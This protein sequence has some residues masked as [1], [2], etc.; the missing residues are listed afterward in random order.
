MSTAV[1]FTCAICLETAV[2]P[3][4][5][6][7]GQ[8]YCRVCIADWLTT[9][10]TCPLTGLHVTDEPTALTLDKSAHAANLDHALTRGDALL[11]EALLNAMQTETAVA[12]AAA[13][14][15]AASA[16][17]AASESTVEIEMTNDSMHH[18]SVFAHH[19]LLTTL[20]VL[21]TCLLHLAWFIL[22]VVATHQSGNMVKT[23]ARRAPPLLVE[24]SGSQVGV[25]LS[26]FADQN[27]LVALGHAVLQGFTLSHL[28]LHKRVATSGVAASTALCGAVLTAA[29]WPHR[30]F[31]NGGNFSASLAAASLATIPAKFSRQWAACVLLA[32]CFIE[33]FTLH[34][35]SFV[36]RIYLVVLTMFVLRSRRRL[37]RACTALMS[38][39]PFLLFVINL[40]LKWRLSMPDLFL[41][42]GT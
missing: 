28:V 30:L 21:A 22:Y 7:T 5:L 25:V 1:P 12:T 10:S 16:A 36:G 8:V 13:Q 14:Q 23:L 40:N 4:R 31:F 26:L 11:A 35:T 3:V 33:P 29:V 37:L 17:A 24:A 6:S 18:Q 39:L 38:C 34:H 42:S 27:I 2:F 9:K 19:A 20:V 41:T 15:P 32:S